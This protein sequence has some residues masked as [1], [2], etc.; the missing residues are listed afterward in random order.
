MFASGGAFADY[1]DDVAGF[2][3]DH[4]GG[5]VLTAYL[6]KLIW[7]D[8]V[9]GYELLLLFFGQDFVF[10]NAFVFEE[11]ESWESFWQKLYVLLF[12]SCLDGVRVAAIGYD[13]A[14]LDFLILH[15]LC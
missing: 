15:K 4:F 2:C 10:W 3:A 1:A 13:E 14:V 9:F 7:V 11:V 5:W 6:W 12:G 8:F